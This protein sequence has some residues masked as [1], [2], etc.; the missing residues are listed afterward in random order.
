MSRFLPD[1]FNSTKILAIIAGQGLYPIL[2]SERARAA[3]IPTRLIQ[4]EGETSPKLI[5]SFHEEERCIVKV[6]QIGKLLKELK[7]FNASY[8]VMAGQVTPGKLFRGLH[9]DLKAVRMLT[10]L[11]RKNAES[12]FG[13][14][15]NEI[16]KI[17]IHLLDARAFMDED[18]VDDQTFVKGKEIIAPDYAQHGVEIAL[19][20]ARLDI[21]QGVVVS[22]GTVLAV[23]AFEGT[24]S[25][26]LR[27]GAFKTKNCLFVKTGKPNQDTRFDVPIFGLNTLQKMSEAGIMNVALEKNSV[28]ILDKKSVL[29]EAKKLRI[30][31][32]FFNN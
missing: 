29:K 8:S 27:A 31:I 4:L 18:L 24:D 23:E 19:E 26:L 1:K 11:K 9:P 10:A 12:I 7:K 6:G 13:A 3:G 5:N 16:E 30:G 22:R 21:G 17:G 14:I 25:M 15:G 2:L 28:I 32:R 20:I